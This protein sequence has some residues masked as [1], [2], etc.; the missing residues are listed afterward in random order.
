[1]EPRQQRKTRSVEALRK[2]DKD[3]VLL[4]AVARLFWTER[5]EDKGRSWMEKALKLDPDT[6]MRGHGIIAWKRI[7]R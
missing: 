1:M 6:A 3:P 4:T 5:R 2:V 7:K